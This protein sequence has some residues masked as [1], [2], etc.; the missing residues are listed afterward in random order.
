M[1]L[2]IAMIAASTLGFLGGLLGMTGLLVNDRMLTAAGAVLLILMLL[3]SLF[4][5][6]Y[7]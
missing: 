5:Y 6:I 4:I 7:G 1:S 3:P 2:L